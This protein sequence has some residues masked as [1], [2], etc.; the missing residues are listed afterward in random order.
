L[1][2]DNPS[3]F[4]TPAENLGFLS[5]APDLFTTPRTSVIQANVPTQFNEGMI[6]ATEQFQGQ[7]ITEI[8]SQVEELQTDANRMDGAL[9]AIGIVLTAFVALLGRFWRAAMRVAIIDID[10]KILP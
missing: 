3:T 4:A 6:T 10:P 9:W 8:K 5:D 1:H 2:R 7:M